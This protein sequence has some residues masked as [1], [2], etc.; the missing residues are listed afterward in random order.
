MA[1]MVLAAFGVIVGVAASKDVGVVEP[2]ASAVV[3]ADAVGFNV[4][5]GAVAGWQAA[6]Q[7]V[8][9]TATNGRHNGVGINGL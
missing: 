1:V 9:N 3:E 6:R 2:V 7:K 8:I 5:E 4:A